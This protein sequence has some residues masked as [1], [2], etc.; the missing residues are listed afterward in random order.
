MALKKGKHSTEEKCGDRE[1][2]V[3]TWALKKGKH[4]ALKKSV[5]PYI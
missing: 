3:S 4:T 2:E 1:G 5:W